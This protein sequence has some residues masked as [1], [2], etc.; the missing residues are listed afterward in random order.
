VVELAP[1]CRGNV[2]F[3]PPGHPQKVWE[4]MAQGPQEAVVAASR[5]RRQ[6]ASVKA[7]SGLPI[8]T[9]TP[10]AALAKSLGIEILREDEDGNITLGL[11]EIPPLDSSVLLLPKRLVSLGRR[12][13]RRGTLPI[14]PA[15]SDS[16]EIRT[17]ARRPEIT[18]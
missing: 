13:D 17:R 2:S 18:P 1:Q 15:A 16:A 14:S 12:R 3:D 11:L 5:L 6:L 7:L 8:D 10:S 4:L 9:V